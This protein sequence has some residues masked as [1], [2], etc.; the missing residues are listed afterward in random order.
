MYHFITQE[1]AF[2]SS[3]F[4]YEVKSSALRFILSYKRFIDRDRHDI[5]QTLDGKNRGGGVGG[6]R[7]AFWRQTVSIGG[8]IIS[9]RMK[10]Q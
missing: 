2:P 10:I 6:E 1:F 8:K 4:F 7:N 5:L 9:N 3:L